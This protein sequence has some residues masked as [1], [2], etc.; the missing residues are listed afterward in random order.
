MNTTACYN[1]KGV[2]LINEENVVTE[3]IFD[4]QQCRKIPLKAA[5]VQLRR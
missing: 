4:G 2:E 3:R 5:R 1:V